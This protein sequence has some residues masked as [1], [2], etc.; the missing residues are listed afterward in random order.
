MTVSIQAKNV[1]QKSQSILRGG[2]VTGIGTSI[3]SEAD[4]FQGGLLDYDLASFKTARIRGS[5]T[6]TALGANTFLQVELF[7][8]RVGRIISVA[9]GTNNNQTVQFDFLMV[10]L[11]DFPDQPQ[12]YDIQC[13][14]DNVANNGSLEWQ[15]E[16]T[17][18]PN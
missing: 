11:R 8:T 4:M 5:M 6:V 12:D 2:I 3:G 18:L 15:A 14:G 16:I 13:H 7:D 10:Q 9:R 17:E 1:S